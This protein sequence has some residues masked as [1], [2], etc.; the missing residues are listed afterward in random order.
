M[1]IVTVVL[2]CAGIG[3]LEYGLNQDNPLIAFGIPVLFAFVL[4]FAWALIRFLI[5]ALQ[6]FLCIK[7]TAENTRETNERCL[8]LS[9]VAELYVKRTQE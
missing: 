2:L 1:L 3:T 5:A 4:L 9:R 6:V 8:Y 7:D